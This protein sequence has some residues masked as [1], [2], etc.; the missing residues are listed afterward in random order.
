MECLKVKISFIA[1]MMEAVSTPETSVRVCQSTL[2]KLLADSCLDLRRR[3]NQ[4]G[5]VTVIRSRMMKLA[6]MGEMRDSY[7][8]LLVKAEGRLV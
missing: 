8:I 4:K 3:V 7:R 6:A 1:P 5:I 2:R